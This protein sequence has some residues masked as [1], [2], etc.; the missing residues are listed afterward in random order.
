MAQE[1]HS[2]NAHTHVV[3]GLRQLHA[4]AVLVA[5]ST[6]SRQ[7]NDLR[8]HSAGLAGRAEI[9]AVGHHAWRD[10]ARRWR[11]DVLIDDLPV[12]ALA[13]AFAVRHVDVVVLIDVVRR[14]RAVDRVAVDV[15]VRAIGRAVHALVDRAVA[16]VRIYVPV[17]IVRCAGRRVLVDVGHRP[18]VDVIVGVRVGG[19]ILID[20]RHSPRVD[21]LVHVC[22]RAS[23]RVVVG[24]RAGGRIGVGVVRRAVRR[25]VVDIR[26]RR[27]GCLRKHHR[28]RTGGSDKSEI[29][30]VSHV[31]Y[32]EDRRAA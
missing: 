15:P 7:A 14:S 25:C 3:Q 17:S 13:V 30:F 29:A 24:V 31:T 5:H 12:D 11:L 8:L 28:S 22:V 2:G 26:R 21:V 19:R 27:R 23:G 18:R 1:A 20:V 16:R 6:P 4:F 9:L 32:P 10:G